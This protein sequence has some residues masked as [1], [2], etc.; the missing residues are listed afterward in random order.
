ML[1]ANIIAQKYCACTSARKLLWAC[2]H[3]YVRF[4]LTSI[5][6]MRTNLQ[7]FEFQTK[8]KLIAVCC[9]YVNTWL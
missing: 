3:V 9:E 4:M 7:K 1:F 2:V 5:H 6:K 8:N